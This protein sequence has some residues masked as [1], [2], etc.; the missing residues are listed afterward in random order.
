MRTSRPGPGAGIQIRPFPWA[1]IHAKNYNKNDYLFQCIFIRWLWFIQQFLSRRSDVAAILLSPPRHLWTRLQGCTPAWM[2]A[3]MDARLHGCTPA[4]MQVVERRL[5][6]AAEVV[7][8]RLEQ[9]AEGSGTRV[10]GWR[11]FL[12]G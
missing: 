4:W 1:G 12:P 9:A 10:S 2:H 7:E 6:Q 11:V 8:R 5:E 3:C